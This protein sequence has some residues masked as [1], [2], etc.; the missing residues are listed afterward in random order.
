MEHAPHNEDTANEF[1]EEV[2]R[3]AAIKA[4]QAAA[5]GKITAL[6]I[7]KV[8]EHLNDEVQYYAMG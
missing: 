5:L 4:K 6:I 8:Q 2:L 7:T 3:Q 1:E